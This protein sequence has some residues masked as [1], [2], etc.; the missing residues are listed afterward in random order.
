MP[1]PSHDAVIKNKMEQL[2]NVTVQASDRINKDILS[3]AARELR[4]ALD[5]EVF[6]DY[7]A[8]FAAY[9]TTAFDAFDAKLYADLDGRERWLRNLLFAEAYFGLYIL[10]IS[11]R[12]LVKGSVNVAHESTGGATIRV[13]P[14]DDIVANAE[15]YREQALVSISA[16]LADDDE[17]DLFSDGSMGVFVV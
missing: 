13:A 7:T 6:D 11:L 9:D 2:A 4:D 17:A 1:T 10:A 3:A 12:K 15:Y 5:A 8:T 16:A 14:Y